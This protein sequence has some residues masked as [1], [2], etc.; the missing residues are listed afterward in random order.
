[1]GW[2]VVLCLGWAGFVQADQASLDP[3]SLKAALRTT[4]IEENDYIRFLVALVDQGRLPRVVVD[5]A[6]RWARQKSY[7]Q[8]QFFKRAVIHHAERLGV[9]L[10]SETPPARADIRGRVV[11]RVLLVDVP[12]PFIEVQ[13]AGTSTKTRTNLAGEFTFANQPWGSYLL[14]AHGGAP[15]LFRTVTATVN[16]P[17]LPHDATTVTLRFP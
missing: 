8:Y 15:Q 1:M 6:F 4:P 7:R 11:Q 17:Y 9:V 2:V 13:I 5:T 10:P 14:E 3:E 12:V 16:L